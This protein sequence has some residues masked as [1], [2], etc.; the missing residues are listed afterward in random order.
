[1][2]SKKVNKLLTLHLS[3]SSMLLEASNYFEDKSLSKSTI[4]KSQWEYNKFQELMTEAINN[5]INISY[6][7]DR[8][9]TKKLPK[10]NIHQILK[11]IENSENEANKL[12]ESINKKEQSFKT[13]KAYLKGQ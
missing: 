12:T 7:I 9:I 4:L 3:M 8:S 13:F 5:N 6:D 11:L 2:D 1:M 10:N